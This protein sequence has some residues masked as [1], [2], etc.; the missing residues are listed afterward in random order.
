MIGAPMHPHAAAR[1][2][3]QAGPGPNRRS[4]AI[5][6]RRKCRNPGPGAERAPH[7]GRG[8]CGNCR[9]RA[10]GNGGLRPTFS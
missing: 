1:G 3:L 10:N 2:Y 6:A 8:A 5:L 7:A 4:C 9:S